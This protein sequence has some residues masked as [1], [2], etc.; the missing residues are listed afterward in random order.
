VVDPVVAAS[1][2]AAVA[3]IVCAW[4]TTRNKQRLDAIHVLV[5]GRLSDALERIDELSARL[6]IEP[7][8][9]PGAE[10]VPTTPPQLSV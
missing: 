8:V 7:R 9:Q 3:S 6:E 5:N 1:V 10:D 2:V 4:L